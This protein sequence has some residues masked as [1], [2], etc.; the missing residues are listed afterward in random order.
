M[1]VDSGRTAVRVEAE[2][3][4]PAVEPQHC[5]TNA[6]G[7]IA[8]AHHDAVVIDPHRRRVVAAGQQ[9]ELDHWPPPDD[10]DGRPPPPAPGARFP[11]P[12]AGSSISRVVRALGCRCGSDPAGEHP[13]HCRSG[14]RTATEAIVRT[15]DRLDF[16]ALQQR[17]VNT[18][19]TV[20]RRLAPARP[21]SFVAFDVL[22]VG[23]VDVRPMRWTVAGF[24]RCRCP[25]SPHRSTRPASGW[26][27]SSSV[28]WRVSW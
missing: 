1:P 28:G 10:A 9:F 17:M 21:A 24:L 4:N 27:P 7:G 11:L 25:R 5:A 23:S 2:V 26:T 20:R 18:A 8:R 16:E 14:E 19:A 12:S 13:S 22:A 6:N 3:D 15:G